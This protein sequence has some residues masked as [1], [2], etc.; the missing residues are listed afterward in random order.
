MKPSLKLNFYKL[1]TLRFLIVLFLLCAFFINQ[2][3]AYKVDA[4]QIS[5][6]STDVNV[7]QIVGGGTSAYAIK[8]D[9]SCWG[10]GNNSDGQLGD[11]TTSESDCWEQISTNVTFVSSGNSSAYIIKSD[12]SLWATGSNNNGQLGDGSTQN[13]NTWEQVLTDVIY[14]ASYN[15][16]AYAVKS[17][18][19]LWATGL[20]SNGELG[21][22]STNN[23][24]VWE[25]VLTGV[26]KVFSGNTS[27]YAIKTDGTLWATGENNCGQL[28]DGTT[29]DSHT[30]KQILTNVTTGAAGISSAEI[31][32][33]DNSLWVAGSN[34]EGEFGDGTTT[35]SHEWTQVMTG[36]SNVAAGNE[37][38]YV[39]KSDGS[40]WATGF[41]GDGELGDGD[42]VNVNAWKEV[43]SNVSQISAG[44][45]SGYLIKTDNTLYAT[46]KN[47]NGQLGD[48]TKTN[49]DLW[50]SAVDTTPP[51]INLSTTNT[52]APFSIQAT[53]SDD[54][55]VAIQKWASG[56]Q[57]ASYFSTDGTTFT[58]SSISGLSAGTY[59]VY[60]RDLYGNTTVQT[61]TLTPETTAPNGSWT[62]SSNTPPNNGITLDGKWRSGCETITFT[63]TDADSGVKCITDPS[64]NT[65]YSSVVTYTVSNNWTYNFTVTDNADNTA[66]VPCVVKDLD[67]VAPSGTY[68]LSTTNWTCGNVT[69]TIN[70]TDDSSGVAGIILPDGSCVQ[71]SAASYTVAENGTYDFSIED[72][73]GNITKISVPVSNIDDMV[74]VTHPINTQYTIDP[75]TNTISAEDITIVNNSAHTGVK[76]SVQSI[77]STGITDVS[78]DA[79]SDWNTLTA[80]QTE[81]NIAFGIGVEEQN[82]AHGGWK[83]IDDSSIQYAANILSPITFGTLDINGTGNFSV[84]IK[85]GRAW[86]STKILTQSIVFSFDATDIN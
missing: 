80:A 41:N 67:N 39:L 28:G 56:N 26:S 66:T 64:G 85:Y 81:L 82:P 3:A 13:N 77:S 33:T 74:T 43:F 22:G 45:T 57:T 49:A 19:S 76:V 25:Q 37:S 83:S 8:S 9:G 1:K 14:V 62:A 58:G 32:K 55:G 30:W 69:I 40:L 65:T 2:N 59:T 38:Y 12:K 4:K 6:G 75:N 16:T 72:N 71:G 5:I 61:I 54:T 68:S 18:G 36:A 73:A 11:G 23:A 70:G 17:D 47:D 52:Y 10:T 79:F 27:V 24:N 60:A 20:N 31:V 84:H 21:D 48:G 42:T 51:T 50:M 63:G 46:G 78:P 86:D 7:V 44:Y 34:T 15:N 53:I 35:D 29:T